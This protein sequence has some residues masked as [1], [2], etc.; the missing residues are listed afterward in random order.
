M[1]SID[2]V[3]RSLSLVEKSV[4][5]WIDGVMDV[6]TIVRPVIR[7]ILIWG[8]EW[9]VRSMTVLD[10]DRGH[11]FTSESWVLDGAIVSVGFSRCGQSLTL[12]TV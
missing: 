4:F 12:V 9:C 11:Y 5:H 2:L 10:R 8:L 6:E 3:G 7:D 1:H